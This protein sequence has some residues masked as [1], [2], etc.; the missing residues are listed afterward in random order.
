[1]HPL[2]FEVWQSGHVSAG[3]QLACRHARISGRVSVQCREASAR[4]CSG[5][6]RGCGR[7]RGRGRGVGAGT[8][9]R[10]SSTHYVQ[11]TGFC[12]GFLKAVCEPLLLTSRRCPHL[13]TTAKQHTVSGANASTQHTANGAGQRPTAHSQWRNGAAP[14]H[15]YLS[16]VT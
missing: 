13:V 5:R 1:M 7:W 10:N 11:P 3:V 15:M 12:L 8:C 6:G 16:V 2:G 14:T 4:C 9:T